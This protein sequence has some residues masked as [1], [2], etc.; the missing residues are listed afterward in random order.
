MREIKILILVAIITGITYWGVEPYAHHVMHPEVAA[1]DYEYNDLGEIGA[2]GDAKRGSE[3]ALANCTACHGI[4]SQGFE[5]PMQPSDSAVAYGVVPPDLSNAGSIYSEKF[6]VNFMKNPVTATHL[7][8]KFD[9]DYTSGRMFPMPSYGWMNDQEIAD[10]AA[11]FKS[12]AK[13]DI[14][15]KEIF[16]DACARCH[17]IKYDNIFATTPDENIKTY[18][19]SIPPDLSMMIRSRGEHYLHTFVN[20]P[21]KLL[22]GTAMPRVGLNQESEDKLV[23]YLEEIGDSKKAER[24][25]L[26]VNIIIFTIIFTI[27]AYLWKVKIW[28]DIH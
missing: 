9:K 12:I 4:K 19:G 23:T 27:F 28:R 15:G 26:G 10:I 3:L 6:M 7:G 13:Q 24:E 20:D 8:H 18:M 5:A 25:S 14:S 2:Q 11:Y 21:Q 1:P 16:E 22:E 17:S